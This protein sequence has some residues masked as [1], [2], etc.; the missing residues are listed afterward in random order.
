VC[1]PIGPGQFPE[2]DVN[3]AASAFPI[4][5]IQGDQHSMRRNQIRRTWPWLMSAAIAS[6]AMLAGCGDQQATG[7]KDNAPKESPV[8]STK[9]SMKNFM[10]SRKAQS[11]KK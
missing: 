10:E 9:D 7:T 3:G 1:A 11:T 4:H 8:L 6:T 5:S 2:D